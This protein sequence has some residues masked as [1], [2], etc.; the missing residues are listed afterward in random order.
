MI[1]KPKKHKPSVSAGYLNTL[2]SQAI[3]KKYNYK[4]A[5]CSY[6]GGEAHHIIKRRHVVLKWDLRNG[7]Y[8]CVKHHKE[9]ETAEGRQKVETFVG[10][11]MDYLCEM[12]RY[13]LQTWCIKEGITSDEF[14]LIQKEKLKRYLN[15]L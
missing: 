6:P 10:E 5:L 7:I 4:C 1:S 11:D 13:I 9:A 14:R 2:W 8:L 3:A 12:D 15:D